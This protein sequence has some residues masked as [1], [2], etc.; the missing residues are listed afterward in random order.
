MGRLKLRLSD[1]AITASK[2]GYLRLRILRG[3]S[4]DQSQG[5]SQDPRF[6]VA[7][8]DSGSRSQIQ[9]RGA[10]LVPDSWNNSVKRPYEPINL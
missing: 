1:A 9:G 2:P 3:R 6:R 7:E 10:R 8:P 5:Q 4:Q